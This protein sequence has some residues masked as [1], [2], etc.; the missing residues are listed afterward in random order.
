MGADD[1]TVVPLTLLDA[2]VGNADI[3]A[4]ASFIFDA[5]LSFEKLQETWHQ[6]LSIRPIM[7]SRI[8]RSTTAPSGL[9]YHVLTPSGM[10]RYLQSQKQAPDHLKDFFCLDECDRS[11]TDFCAGFGVGPSAPSHSYRV[12]VADSAC[13]ADEKRCMAFN[14]AQSLDE[15]LDGDRPATTIQVTRFRDATLITASLTHL[16]GD[17]FTVK[18]IFKGWESTLHG[19]PPPPFEGLGRDPFTAYGPGGELAGN[20]I[21]SSRPP[22]PPGWQIYGPIDKARFASRLLWDTKISRPENTISQKYIFVSADEAQRLEEEAKQDLAKLQGQHPATVTRS[23]VLYAWLLKNSTTHL[24]PNE[25][26]APVTIVNTRAR[27]PT[28]MTPQS[29]STASFPSHNWYG[30]AMATGLPSLKAHTLRSMSLGELALHIK[31]GIREAS[32][33]E[34]TRRFLSYTLHNSLWRKPSG[35]LALFCPP[36]HNWS[37]LTDW[38]L[39]QLQDMDFTPARLDGDAKVEV[40]AFSTHMLTAFSQRDRWVCM[41]Q[42][43]GGVWFVGIAGDRQWDDPRG[44]GKYPRLQRRVR[45][46]RL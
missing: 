5:P 44:F 46:S 42:A 29:E 12:F 20:D 35:K 37:G 34:N 6:T 4:R 30:A 7:Q 13:S 38:R 27:P 39:I 19:N 16:I 43:G 31:T 18:A 33:P 25:W 26:S 40:C 32:T 22:L 3:I 9:E 10:E 24:S 14:G 15:I 21:N 41:G 11:I 23:N 17:L 8:R 45:T 2:T 1:Y 36:G 28:G